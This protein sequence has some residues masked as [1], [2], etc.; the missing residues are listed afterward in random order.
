MSFHF[1]FFAATA[2]GID[3]R[4]ITHRTNYSASSSTPI[5]DPTEPRLAQSFTPGRLY[6]SRCL[7]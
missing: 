1:A 6:M 7:E 5:Q 2:L 4:Y 3:H